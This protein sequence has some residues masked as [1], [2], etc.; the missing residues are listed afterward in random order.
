MPSTREQRGFVKSRHSQQRQN[1]RRQSGGKSRNLSGAD[2]DIVLPEGSLLASV[3]QCRPIPSTSGIAKGFNDI[4]EQVTS[5]YSSE[6]ASSCY[7]DG[8]YSSDDSGS[9][10]RSLD[11]DIVSRGRS[12]RSRRGTNSNRH[13]SDGDRRGRHRRRSPPPNSRYQ[14]SNRYGK[15]I[16]R[17]V[18]KSSSSSAK[19]AKEKASSTKST[20][21]AP[22]APPKPTMKPKKTVQKTVH[23][24]DETAEKTRKRGNRRSDKKALRAENVLRSTR[25]PSFTKEEEEED[26]KSDEENRITV[27]PRSVD[28]KVNWD[29]FSSHK[30][31]GLANRNHPAK[32]RL[33]GFDQTILQGATESTSPSSA[34]SGS[35]TSFTLNTNFHHANA[36]GR[37]TT[38][39]D[40]DDEGILSSSSSCSISSSMPETEFSLNTMPPPRHSAVESSDDV[41]ELCIPQGDLNIELENS[42][43]GPMISEISAKTVAPALRVGDVIVALD[44]KSI[45]RFPCKAVLKILHARRTK[46]VRILKIKQSTSSTTMGFHAILRDIEKTHISHTASRNSKS[47]RSAAK[48]L[49]IETGAL[50]PTFTDTDE[51]SLFTSVPEGMAQI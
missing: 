18:S 2:S 14:R 11:L 37:K 47:I 29:P 43:H 51:V 36:A 49:K 44:G 42:S 46:P 21:L 23:V 6:E 19:V 40:S 48:G 15:K 28:E 8:E 35:A 22:V 27:E 26:L 39:G 34:S 1:Q 50:S 30:T 24:D 38:R 17:P 31:S 12:V 16:D 41:V 20:K 10:G 45:D 13:R 7:D 32:Y 4:M 9:S 3:L 33:Q 25:I 5:G